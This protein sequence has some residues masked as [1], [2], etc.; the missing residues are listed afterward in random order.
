[1]SNKRKDEDFD[2][3]FSDTEQQPAQVGSAK[4]PPPTPVRALRQSPGDQRLPGMRPMPSRQASFQAE[5][6]IGRGRPYRDGIE[7]M[8]DGATGGDISGFEE[9]IEDGHVG[10]KKLSQKL[11]HQKGVKDPDALAASIGRKKYGASGMAKLSKVEHLRQLVRQAMAEVVRKKEGGGGFVLYAPNKGKK[12]SS[13]PAGEFP[14]RLAA[15]RAELARFPPKDPEQLKARRRRLDKLAK[16]PKKRA[17]AERKDLTGTKPIKKSRKPSGSRKKAAREALVRSLVGDLT[18]RLFRDDEIPGSAWDE[19][20]ANLSP[21]AI[22]SDKRLAAMH[23]KMHQN[24]TWALDDAHRGFAKFMRGT[25]KVMPGEIGMDDNRKKMYVPV[26]MDVEGEQVGPIHF[27]ID[28]GHVRCEVSQACREQLANMDPDL[29]RELRGSMM[30]YT[31]DH[32][33]EIEHAKNAWSDRD[34]YLDKLQ[35]KL[36]KHVG[37]MS[38]VEVHLAKQLLNK[39]RRR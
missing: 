10:F 16:D 7:P 11:S 15:K 5:P 18:E 32:L 8:H 37:N 25:A 38:S 23:K 20:L 22:S 28:G 19:R 1:M 2:F 21:D 17:D 14:T 33:P 9:P 29:A 30:T 35:Q 26:M 3:D 34:S 39:Q 13:K 31:E 4:R 6:Q 12:K 27:Y 24:S 36:D